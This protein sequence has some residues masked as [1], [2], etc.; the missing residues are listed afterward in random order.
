VQQDFFYEKALTTA[1]LQIPPQKSI[2]LAIFS[3]FFAK[4]SKIFIC[5]AIFVRKTA[6]LH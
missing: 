2:G 1:K 5:L 3:I 6:K 4:L